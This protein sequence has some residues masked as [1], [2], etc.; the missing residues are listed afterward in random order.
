MTK[1]NIEPRPHAHQYYLAGDTEKEIYG[2]FTFAYK[3][4]CD[5]CGAI[6][7]NSG[8]LPSAGKDPANYAKSYGEYFRRVE[9]VKYKEMEKKWEETEK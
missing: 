5:L 3:F 9:A 2:S 8:W 6:I 7:V 4:K 1:I